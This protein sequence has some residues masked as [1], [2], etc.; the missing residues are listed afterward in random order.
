MNEKIFQ[1]ILKIIICFI[2][3]YLGILHV[4]IK[5]FI[6]NGVYIF[7]YHSFNTFTNDYYR[8]GSLFEYNYKN[9]FEKQINFYLKNFRKASLSER[10]THLYSEKSFLVTFDDGYRDNYLIALPI[11]KKYSVPTIFFIVT[12]A[13]EKSNLLWHDK[14]R[15]SF[16]QEGR[17]KAKSSIKIKKDCKR[18]LQELKLLEKEEFDREIRVI[19]NRIGLHER[20]MMN[21]EEIKESFKTGILIAS[22]THSHPILSKLNRRHQE[23]EINKSIDAINNELK[24][25][26]SIHFCIPDGTL[27]SIDSDTIDILSK[28]GV[29]HVY[30]TEMGINSGK[31]DNL[32]INIY[33]RIAVNPSDP[34][35]VVMIKIIRANLK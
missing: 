15:F 18:K 33:K 5:F 32:E 31:F 11:L 13:L 29:R 6:K 17:K 30:L 9:K 21:W 2:L 23:D 20:L 3:Y 27:A 19:S 10:D 34:I 12:N 25:S 4:I 16:E 1:N 26:K 8:F 7:N 22:H 24:I 14:V 35:P 28:Y